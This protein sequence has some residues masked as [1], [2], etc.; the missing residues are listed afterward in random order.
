MTRV[1]YSLSKLFPYP[2]TAATS[3]KNPHTSRWKLR[4]SIP[5]EGNLGPETEFD[6][7]SNMP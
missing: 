3:T 1:K 5:G 6:S 4:T 7:F 2:T